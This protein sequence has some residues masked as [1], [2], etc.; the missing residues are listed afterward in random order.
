LSDRDVFCDERLPLRATPLRLTAVTARSN[1]SSFA[2]LLDKGISSKSIGARTHLINY[3]RNTKKV[4]RL[5][6]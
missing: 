1:I 4:K 6:F 3:S 5:D 2:T